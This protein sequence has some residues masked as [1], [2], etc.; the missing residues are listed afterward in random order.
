VL[1]S[2]E[3]GTAHCRAEEGPTAHPAKGT[4]FPCGRAAGTVLP[5]ETW[6]TQNWVLPM[7]A[8]AGAVLHQCAGKTWFMCGAKVLLLW[9]TYVAQSRGGSSTRCLFQGNL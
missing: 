7:P 3:G 5:D 1:G 4:G 9:V 6:G 8:I 2:K